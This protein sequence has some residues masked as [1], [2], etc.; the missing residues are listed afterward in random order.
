VDSATYQ[1]DDRYYER[2]DRAPDHRSEFQRDR[3][4]VLYSSAWRR[5]G[6]VTQVVSPTEGIVFHDRLTHTLEVAQIGRRIAERLVSDEEGKEH[7]DRLGGIDADVVE[8]AALVH[9][10]GHPPYGHAVETELNRLVSKYTH[11]GYEGNAQ[12]FR[13]ATKLA[14]RRLKFDGLNLTYASLNAVLKYPWQRAQED[15][16]QERYKD[17]GVD[18][19][20]KW[21]IYSTEYQEY[22]RARSILPHDSDKKGVEAEIMDWADDVAYAVHD[23]EDFYRAGLIPLERFIEEGDPEVDHFAK[24]AEKKLNNKF[25]LDQDAIKATLLLVTRNSPTERPYVGNPIQRAGLKNLSAEMIAD[26]V[27]EVSLAEDVYDGPLLIIPPFL[28]YRVEVL[29]QLTW[30]YVIENPAIKLQQQGQRKVVRD[31]FRAY[32]RATDSSDRDLGGIFPESHRHLLDDAP[33][34]GGRA[35]VIADLISSMTERQL[36]MIHRKLT[37]IE[38]GSITDLM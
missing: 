17:D 20:E 34:K 26:C 21:G 15:D 14:K 10:L 31:L 24:Y 4:R 7:A 1:R 2:G 23:L 32:Y 28:R 9:D 33:D 11:D 6:H 27:N 38:L 29:K 36:L 18:R 35:R 8:T 22:V 37:G 25:G 16:D 12:S 3:D 30:F 13:I 5:L 19:Y